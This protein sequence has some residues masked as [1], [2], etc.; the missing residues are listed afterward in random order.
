MSLA[1]CV[2]LWTAQAVAAGTTVPVTRIFQSSRCAAGDNQPSLRFLPEREDARRWLAS[3]MGG[4]MDDEAVVPGGMVY[5]GLSAGT[6]ATSGYGVSVSRK[7]VRA[8]DGALLLQT[9]WA[10]P[11]AGDEPLRMQVTPCL[12]LGVPKG[13]YT[14]VRAIDQGGRVRARA[15]IK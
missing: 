13:D 9:R 11:Q 10:E 3:Q 15:A 1:A 12:L 8:D 14:V 4:S 6:Y 2:A 7:G 5:I